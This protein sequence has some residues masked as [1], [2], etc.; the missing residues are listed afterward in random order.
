[1]YGEGADSDMLMRTDLRT[2]LS[3]NCLVKTDRASML[4]SLEVR[5]PFLDE[6]IVDRIVA[7]HADEKIVNGQLKALLLPLA[8]RLLPADVWDRPKHGF[9][10]PVEV[11]LAGIWQ[12][13]VDEALAWG[14]RHLPVFN[15]RYLRR[16]QR[17]NLSDQS[18]GLELWN[19]VVLM[20]WAMAQTARRNAA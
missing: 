13:V 10:V 18:V 3:E 7:L 9:N 1:L 14:E 2:Y 15:Y 20:T 6:L 19:P 17:I 16:L 5:V 12:P 4:A 11:K 8:R